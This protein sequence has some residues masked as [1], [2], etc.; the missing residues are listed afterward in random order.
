MRDL[1]LQEFEPCRSEEGARFVVE[2]PSLRLN[3]KAALTLG[4]A[5]HELTTNAAKYGPY[6]SRPDKFALHGT[7][8]VRWKYRSPPRW[9]E[10]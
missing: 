2:G 3:P 6:Q 4:M 5:F 10:K 1:L 8:C 9:E 7:F